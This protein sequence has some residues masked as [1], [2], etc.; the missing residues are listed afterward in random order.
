[1]NPPAPL[2]LPP[3]YAQR[4]W[5]AEDL[6]EITALDALIFGPDAWSLELFEAEYQASVAINAHSFYQV[7]TYRGQIVGFAGVMYGPPFADITTIGVHP[8]HTGKKLGAA[9]LLWCIRTAVTLGAQDMLLEVRADNRTAQQ[10]YA[11][12][13]FTHIH[14]RPKYYPGGIDAWVMRKPLRG[15]E[16]SIDQQTK[17]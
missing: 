17:E 5:T 2:Q 9:L 11:D 3:G 7:V 14:T 13:G 4:A 1:M 8:D 16:A 15:S 12:N 10:L 6:T